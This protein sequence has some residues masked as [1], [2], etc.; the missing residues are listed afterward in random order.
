VNGYWYGTYTGSNSGQGQIVVELDDM[1]DHFHGSAYLYDNN[2]LMPSTWAEIKTPNKS[3]R[4]QFQSRLLPLHPDTSEF[5]EWQQIAGRY[6]GMTFPKQAAVTCE[7][8]NQK[9]KLEWRTDIGTHGAAQLPR[10]QVNEPSVYEPLAVTSWQE[11]KDHVT[12]R[13]HYRY[14]YRGQSRTSRLCT[15]F[16]R[17]GRGDLRRFLLQDIQVL[18]AHLSARTSHFFDLRDPIQNAAFFHLVQHHRYPT[19]LLDWTYSPFVAAYFAYHPVK[20]LD[21]VG[22]SGNEKVRIFVFDK[23]QW[24]L[25]FPQIANTFTRRQHFSILEPAA[26]ENERMVPQQALSSFTTVDDI[27]AYIGSQETARGKRY[28]EIIDLPLRE[29]DQVLRELRV[30]GITQGS[31]F[32]GLDGACEELRERFFG[33]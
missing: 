1:G 19:P 27:E 13:Q 2:P 22:T 10:S 31:L 8:S 3:D 9:L 24:C 30:M 26:I 29:R 21:I 32:P 20:N 5:I 4:L 16:H 18:H 33:F 23:L 14:I 6:P 12:Q 15:P 7:W 17:T 28:L 11:F 25:D